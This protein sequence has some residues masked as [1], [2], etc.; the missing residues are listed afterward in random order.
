MFAQH[1]ALTGFSYQGENAR[2]VPQVRFLNPGLVF[3]EVAVFLQIVPS[4]RPIRT[5]EQGKNRSRT[6][7]Y[8]LQLFANA[9]SFSA[10]CA[11]LVNDAVSVGSKCS[12][13]IL[14]SPANTA[15]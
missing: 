5:G 10:Q 8:D 6:G 9:A 15:A 4:S 12:G 1:Q 14:T 11:K 13:V 2:R 3:L 7:S